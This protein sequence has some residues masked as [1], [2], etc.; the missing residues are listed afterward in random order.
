MKQIIKDAEKWRNRIAGLV[1]SQKTEENKRFV[2]KHLEIL[3]KLIEFAKDE[4]K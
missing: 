2:I 4:N 3:D 1:D